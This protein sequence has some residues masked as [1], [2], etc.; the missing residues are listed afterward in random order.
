MFILFAIIG[1]SWPALAAPVTFNTALPVS[2]G[3]TIV[4]GQV[5]YGEASGGGA[6]FT[7]KNLALATGYGVTSKLAL[8]GVIPFAQ[9]RLQTPIAHRQSTGFGDARVFARY[10]MIQRDGRGNT[11]RIAPFIGAKLPLGASNRKDQLGRLP[12]AVQPGSGTVDGFGGVIMTLANTKWQNDTQISFQTNGSANGFQAG[13]SFR[14]DTSLQVRLHDQ[15]LTS[16]KA[17]YLYAVLEAGIELRARDRLN[18]S[19]IAISGADQINLAPALQLA[20]LRWIAEISF[21]LPVWQNTN[22]AAI[23][24]DFQTRIGLRINY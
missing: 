18:G 1:N 21:L 11:F 22:G 6:K 8:F 19:E 5:I 14:A 15:A 17:A 2:Q 23:S 10:T 13:R 12:Q 16:K 24:S 7:I 4:R 9:K 20:T 3:E